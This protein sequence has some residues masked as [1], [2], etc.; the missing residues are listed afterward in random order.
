MMEKGF[1]GRTK[2]KCKGFKMIVER[3]CRNAL[4]SL[5]YSG[6]WEGGGWGYITY[7]KLRS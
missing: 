2:R 3:R 4:V 7:L 1:L 6:Y 5:G